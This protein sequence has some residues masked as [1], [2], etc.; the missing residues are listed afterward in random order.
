MTAN[1]YQLAA[2]LAPILARYKPAAPA[3]DFDREKRRKATRES[4]RRLRAF[5]K[6]NGLNASGKTPKP[7]RWTGLSAQKLGRARY[8]AAWRTLSSQ[9]KNAAS[10]SA[11]RVRFKFAR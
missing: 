3:F 1:P 2:E 10:P 11:N 6:A 5:R 4:M 7:Q 8:V 9:K